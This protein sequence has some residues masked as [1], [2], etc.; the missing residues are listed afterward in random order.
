M[1]PTAMTN[2]KQFFDCYIPF[3]RSDQC[4]R[5]VEIGSKDVN[6]SIRRNCPPAP[7]SAARRADRCSRGAI[8]WDRVA[9]L[10]ARWVSL[11]ACA[12]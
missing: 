2:S 6:G 3:I 9:G 8:R 1:H 10:P 12:A 11:W 4:A 7:S 5:V